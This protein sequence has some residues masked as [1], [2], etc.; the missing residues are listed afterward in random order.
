VRKDGIV[1]F[2]GTRYASLGDR[3]GS[4]EILDHPGNAGVLDAT[5]L[6]QVKPRSRK[7]PS[8]DLEDRPH[9]RYT[10]E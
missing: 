9:A 3:Y 7:V 5:M 4:S 6:G 2:L 8:T 10:N 1:L